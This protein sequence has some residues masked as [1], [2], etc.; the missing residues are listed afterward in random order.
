LSHPNNSLS[1]S[2]GG[3]NSTIEANQMNQ[4]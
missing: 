2:P 1:L 4:L 3:E